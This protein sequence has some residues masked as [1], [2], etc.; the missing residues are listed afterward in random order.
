MS[1]PKDVPSLDPNDWEG[2]RELAHEML[3]RM[4]DHQR[5]IAEEPAWRQVPEAVE[6]R[7][8]EPAPRRGIG[9]ERSY[10]DFVDLVLPYRT[11]NSHPRFWGWVSGTG[12]PSGM[13]AEMLTAGINSC[14]GH[15]NDSAARVEQQ[16]VDWMRAA[17]G[18]PG[19]TSGVL[20]SGGSVANLVGLAAARDAKAATD[21]ARHG[22][23]A[24][25]GRLTMYTS[26]EVHSSPSLKRRKS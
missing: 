25:T 21:V 5:Q 12:S 4:L 1:D 19:S 9:A 16:V 10:E 22:V 24:S 23:D 3:D 6:K 20:T 11:G 2:Y 15:F 18:M 26:K 7:F 8:H 13:V 14:A 17:M